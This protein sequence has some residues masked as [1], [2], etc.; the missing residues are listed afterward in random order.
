MLVVNVSL[1]DGSTTLR[2]YNA[3]TRTQLVIDGPSLSS[4]APEPLANV[5][6]SWDVEGAFQDSATGLFHGLMHREHGWL[7]NASDWSTYRYNGYVTYAR[8]ADAGL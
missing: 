4:L 5:T 2:G 3:L 8:S 7:L 6:A 1:S